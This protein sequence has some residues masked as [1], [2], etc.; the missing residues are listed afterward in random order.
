MQY[1][2]VVIWFSKIQI[3]NVTGISIISFPLYVINFTIYIFFHTLQFHFIS[4]DQKSIVNCIQFILDKAT[5]KKEKKLDFLRIP[6]FLS[7][8]LPLLCLLLLLLLL[9]ISPLSTCQ[10]SHAILIPC[11]AIIMTVTMINDEKRRMED[12]KKKK[13]K[14]AVIKFPRQAYH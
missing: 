2:I 4:G 11:K 9:P 7:F 6:F 1:Y 10:L 8:F 3:W 5:I 14:M 12:K 13:K